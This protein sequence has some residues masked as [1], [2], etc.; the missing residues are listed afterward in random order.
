M[1]TVIVTKMLDKNHLELR[2]YWLFKQPLQVIHC[3]SKDYKTCL[4]D[5]EGYMTFTVTQQH[6]GKITNTQKSKF[7]PYAYYRM[8][9]FLWKPKFNLEEQVDTFQAMNKLADRPEWE[10][11]REKLHSGKSIKS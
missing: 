11:L 7:Y 9:K 6:K 2:E 5:K 4:H 3:E 1:K 8:Y 10:K